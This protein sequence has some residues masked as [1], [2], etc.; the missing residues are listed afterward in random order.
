MMSKISNCFTSDLGSLLAFCVAN[1]TDTCEIEFVSKSGI[2]WHI[3]LT[4]TID[5]EV[6]DD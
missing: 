5:D 6:T 3:E 1:D 2:R 4:F